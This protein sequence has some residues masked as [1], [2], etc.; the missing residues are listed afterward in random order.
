M[1]R[2]IALVGLVAASLTACSSG[3]SKS[4]PVVAKGSGI[5]ITADELKARLDEQSPFIRARYSTLER[6]KEFLDNLIRF[7]VLAKEAERQGLDK[8]PEV[9][10]T[11]RKIMV[12]KLVQR[13]FQADPAGK[14]VPEAEL[15]KYYDEHKD[16]FSRPRKVRASAIAWNAPAGSPDRA[17]K[18]A[19]AQKALAKVKA[20]EKKNPL[21][22]QQA[23]GEYS[24]DMATK[25]VAGDLGFKSAE[26]LEKAWGKELATA[27]F[28]LKAGETSGVIQG[29]QGIYLV[30]V[31]GVQDELN[32]PFDSVKAQIAQKISREKKTKDFD[33][34]VKKLRDAADVKV[35]DKVLDSIVVAAAPA[36]GTPGAPGM[37][38]PPAGPPG[39]MPPVRGPHGPAAAPA[40]APAPAPAA[41][42]AKK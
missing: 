39:G 3:P 38:M 32:R 30:R 14:D 37:M 41:A 19:A 11:L 25:A 9:I 15:Q 23:V 18:L 27:A 31:T 22:F 12:Q 28:A 4:G 10:A 1:V 5:T 34:L 7:E 20:D 8:D 17:K 16:E 33:E 42:P 29:P 35:D 13:S 21:A 6:K 36:P 2:R 24:E 40:P 26:E